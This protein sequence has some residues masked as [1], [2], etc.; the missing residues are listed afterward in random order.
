M[1]MTLSKEGAAAIG[2][3]EGLRLDAYQDDA[4]V[5]TIGYGHTAGVK[6]GMV[7]TKDQADKYFIQDT[8]E[9]QDSVNRLVKVDVTQAQFDALVSLTFNIGA[10]RLSK[11]TLLKK[12]NAGDI[13]GAALEFEEYRKIT[14]PK[15][16]R[17]V[18]S[19]GLLA[20]RRAE[21][22]QFLGR[23]VRAYD[24]DAVA[25]SAIPSDTPSSVRR[26][27]LPLEPRHKPLD[28]AATGMDQIIASTQE[29]LADLRALSDQNG[30][31][32]VNYTLFERAALG[33]QA[34][35]AAIRREGRGR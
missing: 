29:I 19:K 11:S 21:A 24:G 12:L 34:A 27:S 23:P 2:K 13:E 3:H 31:A 15:T 35:M 18:T 10:G 22:E 16:K 32:P 9:F 7:I 4:G 8:K 26:T 20:R 14:D 1:K 28:G 6:P 30:V 17:K 33:N 25:T 5:W